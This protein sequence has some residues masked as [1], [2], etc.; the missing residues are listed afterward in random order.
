[1]RTVDIYTQLRDKGTNG[2]LIAYVL[3]AAM[4]VPQLAWFLAGIV[5]FFDLIQ[6]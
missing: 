4:F 2:L 1:M 3:G 5:P 6:P